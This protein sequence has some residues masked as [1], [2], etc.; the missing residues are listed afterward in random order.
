[1]NDYLRKRINNLWVLDV[2][3]QLWKVENLFF[4]DCSE[5]GLS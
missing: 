2:L 1:M 4:E 5:E 3:V